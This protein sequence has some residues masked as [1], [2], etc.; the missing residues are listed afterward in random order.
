[1]PVSLE[2]GASHLALR[3]LCSLDDAFD[4]E[5]SSGLHEM[6]PVV[7][8]VLEEIL[9]GRHWFLCLD[10]PDFSQAEEENVLSH[11]RHTYCSSDQAT[12][13]A[14]LMLEEHPEAPLAPE[15]SKQALL[16]TTVPFSEGALVPLRVQGRFIGT[17][18]VTP[19][20]DGDEDTL[21][22]LAAASR[23]I[24]SEVDIHVQRLRRRI[25]A[26]KINHALEDYY[27]ERGVERAMH[28]VLANGICQEIFLLYDRDGLDTA[29]D[30]VDLRFSQTGTLSAGVPRAE[31]EAFLQDTS[32]MPP[33]IQAVIG[34]SGGGFTQS[35]L[36]HDREGREQT[37]G[38]VVFVGG[39]FTQSDQLFL[40]EMVDD[41]DSAMIN[42]H[43]KRRKL[44][45]FLS[46][47]VVNRLL[48][49]DQSE[50]DAQ[51]APRRSKIAMGFAD[52]VGYSGL[53]TLHHDMPL[54]IATL[55]TD[56]KTRMRKITF[57]HGGI[58]DKF[59]G[60][61]LFFH[62]GPWSEDSPEQLALD[63][64]RIAVR[65]AN[66]T[67]ELNGRLT[68]YGMNDTDQLRVSIGLHIGQDLVVG[69]I[70]GEFTAIGADVNITQ[71]I[72]GH[73]QS[74]G[75]IVVSKAIRDLSHGS[76][77]E[78][79]L[80]GVAAEFSLPFELELKGVGPFQVYELIRR[81]A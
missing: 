8:D 78:L 19:A 54:E 80:P 35:L 15:R 77:S 29:F 3:T 11:R 56:W 59:I 71:R 65:C 52:I 67:D 40:A 70:G 2:S 49:G 72:Q 30:F 50:I 25:L 60:D 34:S 39:P 43:E 4:Q 48:E 44:C 18:G 81:P 6:M 47:S 79:S 76:L 75:R 5:R 36:K 7:F 10:A 74:S 45:R 66:D 24:D 51:M 42:Y 21:I 61:C 28:V 41:V 31:V 20:E 26:R 73:E 63:A 68:Q 37:F 58:V 32:E 69:D 55:L 64:I 33:A 9:P 1:M 57:D 53:C 27:L 14:A 38:A 62:R 46:P 23:R 16:P 13:A 12:Q 17:L 22:V